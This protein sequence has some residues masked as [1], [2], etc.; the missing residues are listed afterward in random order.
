MSFPGKDMSTYVR[1]NVGNVLF[2]DQFSLV[3]L[4]HRWVFYTQRSLNKHYGEG[5]DWRCPRGVVIMHAR[6]PSSPY[7]CLFQ[8]HHFLQKMLSGH[9]VAMN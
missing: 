4:H 9:A 6:M 2:L 7:S 3:S 8:G 1:H 5:N